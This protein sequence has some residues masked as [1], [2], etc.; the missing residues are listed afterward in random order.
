MDVSNKA[1]RETMTFWAERAGTE[2]EWLLLAE[3][4]Q[5]GKRAGSDQHDYSGAPAASPRR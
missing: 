4:D 3:A 1:L 5:C 2:F